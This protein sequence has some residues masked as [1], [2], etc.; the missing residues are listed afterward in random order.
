MRPLSTQGIALVA[1]G[2]GAGQLIRS[3]FYPIADRPIQV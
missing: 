1:Q 2:A 3:H